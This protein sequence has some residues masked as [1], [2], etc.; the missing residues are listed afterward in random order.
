MAGFSLRPPRIQKWTRAA[1]EVAG[2]FGVFRVERLKMRDSA[3]E[4]RRDF[5]TFACSE[6]SNV[7]AITEAGDLV[8]VWQYRF[9]TDALS[10]E[11]PGG[12]VDP[13]ESPLLAARRELLE[14][15]GYE[16]R[17]L[18]PLC[19]VE[20]N[21]ALQNNRCHT[22]LARNVRRVAE[23]AFDANEECELCLVPAEHIATLL[24]R[25]HV[26]HAL[27]RLALETYLRKG[28]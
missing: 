10:L 11:I 12:V 20:A 6:W 24:D 8:L 9:G 15:S 4:A 18:T 26:T 19:S 25:D 3:G 1:T 27:V 13:G 16:A 2:D 23:P 5:F 17:E 7:V 21:P 22:F 14:E 28:R